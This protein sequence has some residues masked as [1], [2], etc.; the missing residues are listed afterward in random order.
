MTHYISLLHRDD[1][2]GSYGIQFPDFPGCISVGPEF[3]AAVR[4]G[5]EA[6][7]FHAA[8][9]VDD[10]EPVPA[11]SSLEQIRATA[12]WIDWHD[13]LIA[14]VPLLPAPEIADRVNVTLPR[15]LLAQIDAV[16]HNRSGFLARAAADAL[17]RRI[18]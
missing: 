16:T 8:G 18:D 9:M 4:T 6:L 10:G 14:L 7:S 15:R 17:Q 1:N 2:T 13:A 3:D 5:S 11:P 12:S